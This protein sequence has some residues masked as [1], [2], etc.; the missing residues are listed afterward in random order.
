MGDLANLC[1]L[2]ALV[3]FCGEGIAIASEEAVS[4]FPDDGTPT[5]L[6]PGAQ[7]PVIPGGDLDEVAGASVIS[8]DMFVNLC[9]LSGYTALTCLRTTAP[10]VRLTEAI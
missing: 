9:V 3:G 5:I 6:P 7:P 1:L 4:L 2:L 8:G 10:L